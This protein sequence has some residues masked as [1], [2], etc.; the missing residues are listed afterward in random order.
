MNPSGEPDGVPVG[1][2]IMRKYGIAFLVLVVVVVAILAIAP[3]MIDVNRYHDEIQNQLTAKLGRPVQLGAMSLSLLPPKFTVRDAM[4][5]E[6]PA[7]GTD[8]AFVQMQSMAVRIQL[9]PLLRKEVQIQSLALEHPSVELVKNEQGIWNFA[10]LGKPNAQAAMATAPTRN[11]S[12]QGGPTK[13]SPSQETTQPSS[14]SGEKL[15]LAELDINDGTV[16]ITDHQKHQPRAVYDHIDLRLEDFAGDKPFS[17]A[18]AAHLPGS[19]KQVAKLEGHGGPINNAEML[20]TPFEGSLDLE[21][22]S[23]SGAQKFLNSSALEDTDAVI[24]GKPEVKNADGKL[25]SKGS[26]RL[27]DSHVHGTDIGYPI[28]VD[29]EVADDLVN[30]IIQI[31]TANLKLGSTPVSLSGTINTKN[32]TA[33][34]DLAIKASEV[35]ISEMARLAGAFGVAFNPGMQITG[36][37]NADIHAQGELSSPALTGQLV[38]RELVI[39]GKDVP[40]P[41][42][43]PE[44]QLQLTPQQISSN[45]FVATSGNTTV[46]ARLAMS[47][48]TT[49]NPVLDATIKMDGANVADVLSIAKAAGISAAEGTS[50]SGSLW[51]DVHAVGPVKNTEAMQFTGTGS[52]Q[53]ASVKSAQLTQPLQIH[54]ATLKFTQNTVN[55]NGLNMTLGSTNATG[56]VAMKNFQAPQVQF[57]LTA[58]NLNV[59]ELQKI[60]GAPAPAAPAKTSRLN[61]IA[62]ANALPRAPAAA[63]GLMS[64][65]T[66]SG[67][68]TIGNILYNQLQ[69]QNTKANV[70]LDHGVIKLDPVSTTMYGGS[71]A[72]T[73]TVDTR[74]ATTL[75]NVALK[76][77]KVD[78]NRLLSSVSSV[79]DVLFGLLASNVQSSFATASNADIARSLNG[80]VT[81]NLSNGKLARVDILQQ[82]ASL[83]KFTSFN[84]VV[85]DF[86][87]LQ[88]LGGDFDIRNGVATTNNLKAL[89]EGGTLAATGAVNLVDQS[90]NMRLTAVLSKSYSQQ[91][92]GNQIGGFMNTALANNN[93]EL[94]LPMLVTGT[95]QNMHFAPDVETIAQMKMNNLLP[96][97]GNPG[98]LTTGLLGAIA[99]RKSGGAGAQSG[100]GGV[101]DAITGRPRNTQQNQQ[102]QPEAATQNTGTNQQTQQQQT[103]QQQ[104][105]QQQTQQQQQQDLVNGIVGL[106]GGNKKKQQQQQQQPPQSQ[107]A[108]PQQQPPPK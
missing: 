5:G 21:Q 85:Q 31:S 64:K 59:D 108:A 61:L 88:Q 102:P 58:D 14:Q 107:P 84:R 12:T 36:R 28:S 98:Q 38:A 100:I 72:G 47:Q 52:L 96:S 97:F 25:Q 74:G 51:L 83:G 80:H 35:S 93:G 45:Q 48:Y 33:T 103:Q 78:S 56:T 99:G 94:V 91:V 3:K 2:K 8:R 55:V 89:I 32:S 34:A 76:T 95:F 62:R 24:T 46:N 82:M 7:F 23:L 73:I 22:V 30:D 68:V 77:Q 67:Q 90:V 57:T 106:F 53:S 105:Q 1:Q 9:L 6:D 41:V 86:T 27:E 42:K 65:T 13:A 43:V 104:T 69:L 26:L 11:Q 60:L 71:A 17:L 44:L 54:M 4:I 37:L 79:K 16:A 75:Y 87:V 40:V 50:G 81:M 49:K 19:G 10:S 66:G 70:T 92:G 29:Y 20:K 39:S 15:E 63:P 101:L 18:L